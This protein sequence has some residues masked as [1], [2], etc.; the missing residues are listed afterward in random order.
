M[1]SFLR[2]PKVQ[3]SLTLFLIYL[4]TLRQLPVEQSLF[5]LFISLTSSIFFDLL[6]TLLRKKELFLPWAAIVTGLIIA[7]IIDLDAK[8]YQVIIT[9]AIAMGIKNFVRFSGRHVFNPAASGLL[10]AGLLFHQYVTWWGVSFQNI[11]ATFSL[12]TLVMFFILLLPLLI[13]GY[14]MRRY[15]TILTF[16]VMH[17]LFTHIFTFS[18]SLN[19][20]I[21]R[22]LDP[23][24]IFF[25]IVMLPEPM[26]SPVNTKRQML[27]G[28]TVAFIALIFSSTLIS[29]PLLSN[30]LLPDLFIPALLLGNV[31]FFRYR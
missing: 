17:T 18:L 11:T 6:Y 5:L 12:Q 10:L 28:A 30:G 9:C 2:I 14:R 20:L 22:L 7:L 19:S 31:L 25:S 26:T 15:K 13:S 29:E 1:S 4:T 21:S 8:W 3:L 23:T 27:F 24:F 16:I